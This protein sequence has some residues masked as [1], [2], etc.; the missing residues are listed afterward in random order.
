MTREKF[1]EECEQNNIKQE[2]HGKNDK[3]QK[4]HRVREICFE[5]DCNHRSGDYCNYEYDKGSCDIGRIFTF[6]CVGFVSA[7][8]ENGASDEECESERER[9]GGVK[10]R[11]VNRVTQ[12][13]HRKAFR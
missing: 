9:N 8:V 2:N 4:F 13:E 11:N 1:I 12:E 3:F 5:I 7:S 6:S 10:R